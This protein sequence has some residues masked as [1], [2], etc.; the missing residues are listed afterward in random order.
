MGASVC[1]T[2]PD[3]GTVTAALLVHAL[4]QCALSETEQRKTAGRFLQKRPVRNRKCIGVADTSPGSMHGHNYIYPNTVG[5][6]EQ[7]KG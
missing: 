5:L 1:Q 6:V 7:T 2:K 3:T 4:F